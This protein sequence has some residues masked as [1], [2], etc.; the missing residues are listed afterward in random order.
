MK[1]KTI[2]K[3]FN[4]SLYLE[5]NPDLRQNGINNENLARKHYLLF[6]YDEKRIYKKESLITNIDLDFDPIFYIS[7]YPDVIGYYKDAHHISQIEK[8]FHHYLHY[9]KHEGRFKNK[10]EQEKSLINEDFSILDLIDVNKLICPKNNLECVCLLTTYK[11][12]ENQQC[13]KFFNHLVE[14]TKSSKTTKKIDFKIILNKFSKIDISSLKTI[15]KN[16]EIINLDLSKKDDL[17][18]TSLSSKETLPKYGL[19]SGPN[20]MFFETI[21]RSNKYNTVLLLETDCLLADNW[22]NNLYLYVKHSN[23]FLISGALYDGLVFTKAGSA[24]MNHI[25]GGTALYATGNDVLQKLINL[26]S[27]FLE[28]QIAY[29]MPGLAYDYGLKLLIDHNINYNFNNTNER[30]VW[31]FI[32]RNYLPC[33]HIINCSTS[34]DASMDER[35]LMSMYNFSVLHKKTL[36]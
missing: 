11:E 17:Y 4:Y 8:L 10:I 14:K 33:K 6:G 19:K 21:N 1:N 25:N 23:G 27:I 24:M 7:E 18:T 3:D 22:I 32:N 29:N 36:P 26:L 12:I 28:K 13:Q 2:P 20:S 5:Y 34:S 30:N 9:G 16:V 35:V 31:Q 15:F